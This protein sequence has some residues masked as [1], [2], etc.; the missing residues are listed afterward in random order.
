FPDGVI[1]QG[2]FLPLEPS[3]VLYEF[4]RSALKEACLDFELLGPAVPKS[5][6][7]PCYAKVGEKMP[8]LEDEDLVPAAL[9][10]FKPNET[11]SIVFTGLRND[12]LA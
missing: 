3:T 2:V 8:T 9:V 12:L 11:D 10:K 6:V 7:I 4:A 1:L 5:R